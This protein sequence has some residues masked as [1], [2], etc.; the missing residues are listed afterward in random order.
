VKTNSI[1][2]AR[3][4]LDQPRRNE[5]SS[6]SP[7]AA[8]AEVKAGTPRQRAESPEDDSPG[9]SESASDAL[10]QPSTKF[11][12]PERAAEFI[13]AKAHR[14]EVSAVCQDLDRFVTRVALHGHSAG[15]AAKRLASLILKAVVFLW[16]RATPAKF[17]SASALHARD[18]QS[19]TAD[20]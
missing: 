17:Q 14:S 3:L 5:W 4:A 1:S 19:C 9:Q 11:P 6:R 8:E 18:K 16:L 10:G 7:T 12:S 15:I 13:N 2:H 20:E